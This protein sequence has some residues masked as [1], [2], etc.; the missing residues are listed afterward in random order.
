MIRRQNEDLGR[1]VFE[2]VVV[3]AAQELPSVVTALRQLGCLRS[4]DQG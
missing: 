1:L 2:P 3:G 4:G